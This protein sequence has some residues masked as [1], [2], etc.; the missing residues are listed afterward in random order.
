M[1][2]LVPVNMSRSCF[3]LT[4]GTRLALYWA[5]FGPYFDDQIVDE[6]GIVTSLLFF[7]YSRKFRLFFIPKCFQKK[8][9]KPYVNIVDFLVFKQY[10][11][12]VVQLETS[13]CIAPS[14]IGKVQQRTEI[15]RWCCGVAYYSSFKRFW[16]RSLAVTKV[17]LFF[18]LFLVNQ[19]LMVK[20]R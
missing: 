17:L 9:K 19:E 11:S 4:A 20:G 5:E 2:D 14:K 3:D 8:K 1:G 15:D 16:D 7:F 13:T 10:F 12:C 6:Q 18:Y